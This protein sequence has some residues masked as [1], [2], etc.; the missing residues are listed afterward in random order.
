MPDVKNQ[1]FPRTKV[2]ETACI[3]LRLTAIVAGLLLT[4]MPFLPGCGEGKQTGSEPSAASAGATA[5][6]TR[7]SVQ[8]PS[9]S[10]AISSTTAGNHQI[11][12]VAAHTKVPCTLSPR[13][14]WSQ[15]LIP[16]PSTTLRSVP[17]TVEKAPAQEKYRS[18]RRGSFVNL[19]TR[20]VLPLSV[21]SPEAINSRCSSLRTVSTA[22]PMWPMRRKRSKTIFLFASGTPCPRRLN[23]GLP[24]V[25]GRHLIAVELLW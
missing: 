19:G 10:L 13:Q 5:S 18:S 14:P 23:V 3:P 16:I 11:T 1:F 4:A 24:H 21:S 7:D 15:T 8:D 9:Q 6:V 2:T 20:C 25:H 22:L 17:I 12:W